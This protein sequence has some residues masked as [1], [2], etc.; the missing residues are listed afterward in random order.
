MRFHKKVTKDLKN[1]GEKRGIKVL[2]KREIQEKIPRFKEIGKR[3]DNVI[4]VNENL[5][6]ACPIP[7]HVK[8]IALD[9]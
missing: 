4:F 1:W 3:P 7:S 9:F 5:R 8:Y 2:Q 6:K